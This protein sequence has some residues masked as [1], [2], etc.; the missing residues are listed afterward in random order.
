MR[1]ISF[2]AKED[3]TVLNLLL[4]NNVSK[5]LIRKLKQTSGGITSNGKHIRTIDKVFGGD[6]VTITLNDEKTL[7][8]NGNLSV[9]VLYDC[10]DLIAF[11]KPYNMPVHPSIKHQNDTLGNYFSHLCKGIA[12]RPIN[13]LDR[14]TSGICV[15]AKNAFSATAL[16][17]SL[18]KTYYAIACGKID[19]KGTI[20][21]PIARVDGSII[22]RKVSEHGQRAITHFTPIKYSDNGKY[23]LLKIS[24]ETGRTHQ[25]RVHFSHL[26][27]PLAGDDLYGGDCSDIKRQALHCKSV[28]FL[29]PVTEEKIELN[30]EIPPD[31]KKLI[32]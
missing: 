27:Y 29:H 28:R 32:F 5:R 9:P 14:D 23:T 10:D 17:H 31:M 15:V 26:G 18:D 24:L 13:R 16:Q 1:K 4:S 6:I 11:D 3:E 12:F 21:A 19:T 8:S 25:I 22:T 20:D 30:S 2:E 7:E